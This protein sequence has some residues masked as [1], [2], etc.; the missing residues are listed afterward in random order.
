MPVLT[1]RTNPST[2]AVR[3]LKDGWP[4]NTGT[5]TSSL[6]ALVRRPGSPRVEAYDAIETFESLRRF[7]RHGYARRAVFRIDGDGVQ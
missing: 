1:R 6:F 3:Q 4:P 5:S 2:L 7:R